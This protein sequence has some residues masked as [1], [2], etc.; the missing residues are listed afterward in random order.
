MTRIPALLL[1]AALVAAAPAPPAA[2]KDPLFLLKANPEKDRVA[3]GG[4]IRV[5]LTLLSASTKVA[6]CAG[7][8]LGSPSGVVLYVRVAGGATRQVSRLKGRFQ[9]NDFKESPA[10]REQLKH[11]GSLTG[12]VE[13]LAVQPGKWEITASYGGVDKSLCPDPVEAKPFTVTVDP[14]PGGETR[15]GAKIRTSIGGKKGSMVAELYPDRAFN[16]VV[17]FLGLGTGSFYSGHVFHRI[18]KDFM[19]QTGDPKGNGTGG[20]G[21]YVPGEVNDLKFEKGVLAMALEGNRN[22]GGSQF[23]ILT[24]KAPH[25]EGQ[26][27]AFGRIVEGKETLDALNA[28]PVQRN[29]AGEPSDPVEKPKLEGVDLVLLK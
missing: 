13:V 2:A 29:G 17:N 28:V 12:H 22:S 4:T 7:L 8:E 5:E 20:P 11:G 1:A 19:V 24:G 23:F 21:Y 9:G 15:V 3:L 6:A 14:G 18:I 26:F 27:T 10:A 16:T 25:L